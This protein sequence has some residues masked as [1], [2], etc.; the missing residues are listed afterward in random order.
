MLSPVASSRRTLSDDVH[1]LAGL[2]GEVL[3]SSGG[4]RAFLQTEAARTLAKDLRGGD[5][6]AGIELDAMVRGLP[7]DEAETL[8]RAFTNY[9]QLINLAEDSERI[10]RIRNREVA[11]GGPRRGSLMEAVRLLADHGVDAGQLAELLNHARVRLVLT[12]HPTEARR[13]TI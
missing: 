11:E 9:F 8:V 10:R 3:R 4:E 13:R 6:Q 1:L 2:L 5:I 12:A 7:D